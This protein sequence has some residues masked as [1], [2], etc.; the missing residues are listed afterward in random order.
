[1]VYASPIRFRNEMMLLPYQ[2]FAKI[3]LVNYQLYLWTT[4]LTLWWSDVE[5]QKNKSA[6]LRKVNKR[7]AISID[8]SIKV[9]YPTTEGN[10]FDMQVHHRLSGALISYS[11]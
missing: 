11:K 5:R 6:T 8:S 2:P 1:M 10:W 7:D 4:E 9:I 3:V